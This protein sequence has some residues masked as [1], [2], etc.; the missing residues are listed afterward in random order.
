[1]GFCLFFQLFFKDT[2]GLV[3]DYFISG[4]DL[5][6]FVRRAGCFNVE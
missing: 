4:F 1:M 2:V 5:P 3:S 6:G